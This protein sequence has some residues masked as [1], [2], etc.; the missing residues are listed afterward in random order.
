MEGEK[1]N[2]LEVNL[3]QKD[4]PLIRKSTANE[5]ENDFNIEEKKADNLIEASLFVAGRYLNIEELML[6]T[7]LSSLLIK[8][9]ISNLVKKY[10]EGPIKIISK[11]DSWKMDISTEYHYLINKLATGT[12]EFTKAEQETLAVIAYKQPIKQSIVIKIRGNKAYDHIKK[13][14]NLGLVLAKPKGHT[15]ELNLSEEFYEYFNVHNKT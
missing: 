7:N 13:F 1:H 4:S 6:L 8:N 9:S 3:S 12:S 11:S 10:S 14:E 15:L 2:I 5:I